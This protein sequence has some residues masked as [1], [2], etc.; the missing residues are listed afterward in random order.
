MVLVV[1]CKSVCFRYSSEDQRRCLV[2]VDGRPQRTEEPQGSKCSASGHIA[3]SLHCHKT[4]ACGASFYERQDSK[5][6]TMMTQV[7][8]ELGV[9]GLLFVVLHVVEQMLCVQPFKLTGTKNL[10]AKND[11]VSVDFQAR[12]H[13]L[14]RKKS[15]FHFQVLVFVYLNCLRTH[16]RS[17]HVHYQLPIALLLL[18]YWIWACWLE[19]SSPLPITQPKM[20][21]CSPRQKTFRCQ[22]KYFGNFVV[23]TSVRSRVLQL[24]SPW[25]RDHNIIVF[26]NEPGLRYVA[27]LQVLQWISHK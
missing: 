3:H 5:L 27:D 15:T 17:I 11:R 19:L 25:N 6:N 24:I 13:Q 1:T 7:K 18:F 23:V 14:L 10:R 8:K 12:T 16:P 26:L 2:S 22:E 4:E 20:F 21:L 9:W